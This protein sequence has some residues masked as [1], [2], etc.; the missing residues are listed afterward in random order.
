MTMISLFLIS[1]LLFNLVFLGLVFKKI[2]KSNN[3]LELVLVFFIL[4]TINISLYYV[5]INIF[6]FDF[7][8]YTLN[9]SSNQLV[10]FI[11]PNS[12]D[13]VRLWPSG[14]AQILVVLG[15][16]ALIYRVIPGSPRVKALAGLGSLGVSISSVV[17]NH[18][19]V[20]P[21]GF[22]RLM[23]SWAEYNRTGS[24][25][26]I[27]TGNTNPMGEATHNTALEASRSINYN[28]F[29]SNGSDSLEKIYNAVYENVI[30]PILKLLRPVEVS[31]Y[32]DDLI[33]QRIFILFLL[34][35]III[36]LI[37]L[38]T[39]FV[40]I[41][42]FLHN[43][44]IFINRFDNKFLKYYIKYQI[45]LGKISLFLLPIFIFCGLFTILMGLFF[46]LTHPIPYEMLDVDL[47]TFIGK[48]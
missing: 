18:A 15:V 43:K 25:A 42:I 14:L 45:F 16:F 47:H 44:D 1:L 48:K 8:V 26:A 3:L 38:F 32:L 39:M 41:N 19:L 6:S 24:W 11:N 7:S 9:L 2:I 37:I 10:S 28:N 21:N 35:I 27:I 22:D 46:L 13:P 31:G 30:I 5:I 36:S 40:F 17:L 23:Y 12:T 33:G 34:F 4:Y 29:I 20:N